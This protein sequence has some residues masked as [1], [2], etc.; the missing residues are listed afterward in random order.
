VAGLVRYGNASIDRIGDRLNVRLWR[1]LYP[2]EVD[3]SLGRSE[4]VTDN[5]SDEVD[6]IEKK[7]QSEYLDEGLC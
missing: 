4:I 1:S 2:C 6:K 3:I 5:T 7:H